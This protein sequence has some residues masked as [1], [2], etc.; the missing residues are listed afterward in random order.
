MRKVV[1]SPGAER[2]SMCPAKRSVGY[3]S[4]R[5]R[6]FEDSVLRAAIVDAHSPAPAPNRLREV[7]LTKWENTTAPGCDRRWGNSRKMLEA[8]TARA[9]THAVC[10]IFPCAGVEYEKDSFGRTWRCASVT[11]RA[12]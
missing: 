11:S 2:T 7:A 5:V 3:V 12:A 8:G 1:P 9:A 4:K 10:A 6:I